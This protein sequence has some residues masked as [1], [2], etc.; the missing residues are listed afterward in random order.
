MSIV[1]YV[2]CAFCGYWHLYGR[3]CQACDTD[4]LAA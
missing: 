1:K 2:L 4:E 3:R